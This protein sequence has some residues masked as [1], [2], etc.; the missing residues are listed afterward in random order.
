MEG[1]AVWRDPEGRTRVL[2]VSDDNF[3]PL[4]RTILAEYIVTD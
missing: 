2:L 3:F 4:Q 1:I